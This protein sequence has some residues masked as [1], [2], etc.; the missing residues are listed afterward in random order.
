MN[1][2]ITI[3]IMTTL[4]KYA[5]LVKHKSYHSDHQR[6]FLGTDEFATTVV[7]VKDVDNAL[8]VIKDLAKEGVQLVELCGG[9]SKAEEDFLKNHMNEKLVIGRAIIAPEDELFLK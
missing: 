5:F 7:G 8:E 2:E 6:S 3:Y 4:S 1:L 9:F